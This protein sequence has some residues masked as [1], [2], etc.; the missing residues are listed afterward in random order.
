MA[1]ISSAN[2]II[3]SIKDSFVVWAMN[4][5]NM[6]WIEKRTFYSNSL[7]AFFWWYA[8]GLV[9]NNTMGVTKEINFIIIN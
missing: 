4:G 6:K 7:E 1:Q 9:R 5:A 2:E 8:F 3:F